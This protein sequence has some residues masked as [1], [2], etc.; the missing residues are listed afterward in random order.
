MLYT[1]FTLDSS[2]VYSSTMKM[3]AI[4]FS[5]MS[6][7]VQRTIRCYISKVGPL[8]IKENMGTVC[9]THG[10]MRNVYRIFVENPEGTRSFVRSKC[11]REYTIKTD[12]EEIGCE[13]MECI[14]VVKDTVHCR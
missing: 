12:L 9:S 2:L 11:I 4:Y 1:C 6:V 5:E 3:E 10:G 7:D 13:D 8:Q 14:R